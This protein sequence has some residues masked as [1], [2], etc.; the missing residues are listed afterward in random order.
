MTQSDWLDFLA[1][2]PATRSN[3]SR[4]PEDHRSLVHRARRPRRRPTPPRRSRS[5]LE[6]EGVA[7]DIAAYRAA[8]PGLRI[9]CGATVE[10]ADLE[11][12]MP[13]LDWAWGEVKN[14]IR[15]RPTQATFPTGEGA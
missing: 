7:L 8:P 2:D 14:A 11:A 5:L 9:W 6:N 1:A 12:L 10:A 3:T 13:W 4:V 15:V